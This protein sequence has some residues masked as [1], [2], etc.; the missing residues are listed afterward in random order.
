MRDLRSKRVLISG[1]AAGLGR[2]LAERFAGAGASTLIA[3]LDDDASRQ[4]GE[5]IASAGR[6]AAGYRLDVGDGGSI[7]ALRR[8]IHA[9]GGPIDILVNNA[10]VVH[11]GSFLD[12][13]ID[14]HRQTYDVNIM[15]LVAMT[16]A[17]LPDLIA[18]PAGHLVNVASASGLI[19]LPFAST[20]ASSKWAVIG[21]TESIRSELRLLGHDHVGVT[22]VCPGYV[23]TG[24]F[25]G[26]RPPLG[27][28]MIEPE[29]VAAL[30]VEGVRR[31]RAAILTPGVVKLTP[32]F[33]GIMPRRLFDRLS[34]A[35]GSDI[36]MMGW[37]GH[38]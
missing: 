13:P 28:P 35:L 7:E 30:I 15:G 29:A 12:V 2:C 16:H 10:G 31:G 38:G 8:Q 24:M 5:A 6:D 22:V 36:S 3:D 19:G 27:A 18:R 25:D 4:L 34:R 1:G 26:V 17:F 33:K 32:F 21:F 20:Y 11:G 9:D 14:R 37:R 23:N